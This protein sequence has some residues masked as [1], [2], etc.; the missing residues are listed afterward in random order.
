MGLTDY[1]VQIWISLNCQ[2][3]KPITYICL[4]LIAFRLL[5]SIDNLVSRFKQTRK[6]FE[7]TFMKICGRVNGYCNGGSVAFY[8]II[9]SLSTISVVCQQHLAILMS[10]C[11]YTCSLYAYAARCN[12]D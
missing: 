7:I 11:G 10:M 8:T 4:A 2:M 6:Q 5:S 3:L 9:K 1:N 12:D